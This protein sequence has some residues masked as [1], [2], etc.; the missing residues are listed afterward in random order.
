M[1]RANMQANANQTEAK[2]FSGPRLVKAAELEAR[3]VAAETAPVQTPKV[4]P[5]LRR[6]PRGEAEAR[7]MFDLLFE[8]A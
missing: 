5:I 8:A 1:K 7:Q 4:A 6:A 3:R 2:V